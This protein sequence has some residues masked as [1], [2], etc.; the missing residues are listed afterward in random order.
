MNKKELLLS[1]RYKGKN[2]HKK[3]FKL[4]IH[5]CNDKLSDYKD[6][7]H[8]TNSVFAS[9]V[10]SCSPCVIVGDFNVE[11][12]V[13]ALFFEKQNKFITGIPYG[14]YQAVIVSS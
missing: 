7:N 12:V 6:T 14:I 3:N 8:I 2:M 11:N 9:K 10:W 1:S 5:S 13:V 4:H